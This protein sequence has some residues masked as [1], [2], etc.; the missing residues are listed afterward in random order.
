M[1]C[2]PDLARRLK[3]DIRFFDPHAPRQRGLNE[4][5][6]GLLRQVLPQ[7]ADLRQFSRR[8]LAHI[9][10]LMN[11][12]PRKT[13]GWKPPAQVLGLEIEKAASMLQVELG[14]TRSERP[15]PSH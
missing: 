3:I 4:T 15:Q 2:Q 7:G 9:A 5:T 12:R 8:D 10:R 1:A 11:D 6:G 14:L 13:P